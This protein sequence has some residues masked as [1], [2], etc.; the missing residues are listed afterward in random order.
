MEVLASDITPAMVVAI[1]KPLSA[2]RANTAHRLRAWIH[3]ILV[4][5]GKLHAP[6]DPSRFTSEYFAGLIPRKEKAQP[7]VN[8]AA[9]AVEDMPEFV[10]RLKA[11]PGSTARCLQ[12][13]VYC[14]LR[15]NEAIGLKWSYI[16]P[17]ARVIT[18]PP[19]AMKTG[20][21]FRV[22]LP[23]RA[24]GLLQQLPRLKGR[25]W[26]FPGRF[27][28]RLSD[29]ALASVLRRIGYSGRA[30]VHGFRSTFRHYVGEHTDFDTS[31]A[32]YALAHQV[33]GKVERAYARG[34]NLLKRFAVMNAW[35]GFIDPAPAQQPICVDDNVVP[36]KAT[37]S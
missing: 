28:G 1:L 32:E 34:D 21:A 31:L 8:H 10:A 4:Y 13:A 18:I 26:V 22:A 15:S 24:V 23:E 37:G 25:E 12:F 14:A 33:G 20:K 17:A 2:T 36:L 6:T 16:D 5:A 19:E 30:T 29:K 35:A 9:L 11:E 7:T 3:S 27:G